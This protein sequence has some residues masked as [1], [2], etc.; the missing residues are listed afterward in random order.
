[1]VYCISLNNLL[2]HTHKCQTYTSKDINK[3]ELDVLC[4]CVCVWAEDRMR[5]MPAGV[6]RLHHCIPAWPAVRSVWGRL[7]Y[8]TAPSSPPVSSPLSLSWNHLVITPHVSA[9]WTSLPST[10]SSQ[11]IAIHPAQPFKSA[12]LHCHM[13]H[14]WAHA[15]TWHHTWRWEQYINWFLSRRK[16]VNKWHW[17]TICRICW[18]PA[19]SAHCGQLSGYVSTTI[20]SPKEKTQSK[21]ILQEF[22]GFCR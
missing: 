16:H 5:C 9:Q 2:Q 22:K 4:V 10:A 17:G 11:W 18:E 3:A 15:V 14:F 13:V 12:R 1:M 19:G 21:L 8:I 7:F 6:C 20:Q